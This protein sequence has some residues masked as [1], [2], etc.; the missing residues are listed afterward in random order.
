MLTA[1]VVDDAGGV[2]VLLPTG[3]GFKPGGKSGPAQYIDEAAVKQELGVAPN[4]VRASWLAGGAAHQLQT[5][6]LS[7]VLQQGALLCS[8]FPA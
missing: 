7:P 4:L 3:S 5:A 6:A 2:S 8:F 1:Q